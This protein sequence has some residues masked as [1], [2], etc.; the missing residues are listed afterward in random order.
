MIT[1]VRV[2]TVKAGKFQQAI[3]FLKEYKAFINSQLDTEIRLGAELGRVGTVV[4]MST[5]ENAQA[6]EN[7]LNKLRSNSKYIAMLDKSAEYFEDEINEHL[8]ADLPA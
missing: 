5:F 4:S 2:R 8:I 3:E 6:W 1:Y 7:A